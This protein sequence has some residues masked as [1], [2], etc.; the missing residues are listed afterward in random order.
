MYI[1]QHI[2]L[3]PC[4]LE[5]EQSFGM[6]DTK[7]QKSRYKLK[8]ILES[9]WE[10]YPWFSLC[11]LDNLPSPGPAIAAL[12]SSTDATFLTDI[13]IFWI[14]RIYLID[15]KTFFVQIR[16]LMIQRPKG[17][18]NTSRIFI[19]RSWLIIKWWKNDAKWNTLKRFLDYTVNSERFWS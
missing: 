14:S 18:L 15:F 2:R 13:L 7:W 12:Y 1:F 6:E 19:L 9:S 10:L 17:D 16:K 3:L 5:Q 4:F 11:L 8:N